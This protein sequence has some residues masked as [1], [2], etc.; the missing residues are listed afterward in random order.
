MH[1]HISSTGVQDRMFAMLYQL[2]R[3]SDGT[4]KTSLGT[5]ATLNVKILVK[6]GPC[7]C[8]TS[9]GE[10]PVFNNESGIIIQDL[11]IGPLAFVDDLI[12]MDTSIVDAYKAHKK[13]V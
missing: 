3:N 9:T 12:D 2:N 13:A 11:K 5:T 6:Q 4:V 7:L 8:R 1:C 10:Y